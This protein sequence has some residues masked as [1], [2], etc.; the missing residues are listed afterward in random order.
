MR[1]RYPLPPIEYPSQEH[2]RL[3]PRLVLCLGKIAMASRWMAGTHL[4][5]RRR[6]SMELAAFLILSAVIL[7]ATGHLIVR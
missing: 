3:H 4:S 7:W 1:H 6:S 2:L 5:V